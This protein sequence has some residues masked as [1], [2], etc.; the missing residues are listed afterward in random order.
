VVADY[1]RSI[2]IEAPLLVRVGLDAH[3]AVQKDF[4]QP[5]RHDSR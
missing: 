4:P 2:E 3:S 5:R 1:H